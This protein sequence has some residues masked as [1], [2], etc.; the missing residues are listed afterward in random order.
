[1]E[2]PLPSD[3]A[4]ICTQQLARYLPCHDELDSLL[5]QLSEAEF[6]FIDSAP[7]KEPGPAPPVPV[8][9]HPQSQQRFAAPKSDTE[10]QAAKDN[11]VPKSTAKTTS[12]AVNVWR[13]WRSHRMQACGSSLACPPHLLLCRDHELDYWLTRFILEVRR[14]DQQPYPP[15]TLYSLVCGIMRY[16][17]ERHPQLN[18]FHDAVFAGFQRAM[19]GEMKRLRALG[20]GVKV[21]RAEP[22]SVQ[23][24]NL[25]WEKGLLGDDSPQVLLDTM[26]FLCGLYLSLRSGKEHRDLAWDQIELVEPADA[27]PFLLYTENVSK[28]NSGGLAQRKIAPKQVTHHANDSNPSRCFVKLFKQYRDHCP[29]LAQRKT[30]AFYLTPIKKPKSAIW[31]SVTA[32]GHNTL[33][34]TVRRLCK[35]A[36]I[37]GFKTNHSLRVTNATRLFQSGV[38]EQLIMSRT[39]HRSVQGVRTYKRVSEDQKLVLSSVLNAA[40]NGNVE[41]VE[42]N[43]CQPQKKPK[44]D[45]SAAC[46]SSTITIDTTSAPSTSTLNLENIPTFHFNGCS[47]ITVNITK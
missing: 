2:A 19:D 30:S 42:T 3:L 1:M 32:V 20:L 40:T 29:P 33:S 15:Q 47:S 8:Q 21:R 12:W 18:F 46:K 36:G 23:E 11:A 37:Q 44:L 24:E 6:S 38:D 17:R 4:D 35:E 26:I 41:K 39:G 10:V 34:Q 31:Y 45:V 9:P 28:N 25:L 14:K 13:E 43:D 22:I 5:S 7:H 16:V 27:P